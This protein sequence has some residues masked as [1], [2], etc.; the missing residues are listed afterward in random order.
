MVNHI[1]FVDDTLVFS[2]HDP[3]NIMNFFNNTMILKMASGLNKNYGKSEMMGI[4][5][6]PKSLQYIVDTHG[7]KMGYWPRPTSYLGLQLGDIPRN[8]PF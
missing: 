4:N 5:I 7:C 6:P 1:E 3:L 8:L 2:S